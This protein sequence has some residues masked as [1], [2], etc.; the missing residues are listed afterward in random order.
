MP[1]PAVLSILRGLPTA[2]GGDPADGE[3]TTP[4]GAALLATI[5][6]EFG[7]LPNGRILA[8][9]VGAG[10]RELADRPNVLRAVLVEAP[11]V[12]DRRR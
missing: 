4:T 7:V 10:T 2:G 11:Q 3:L 6:D 5:V 1:G 8:S 9:G 12:P